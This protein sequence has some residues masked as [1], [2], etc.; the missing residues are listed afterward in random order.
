MVVSSLFTLFSVSVHALDDENLIDSNLSNWVDYGENS[1]LYQQADV[2]YI[3]NNTN[4]ITV[5]GSNKIVVLYDITQ[6]LK[7]GESYQFSFSLPNTEGLNN[8]ALNSCELS[9][10]LCDGSNTDFPIAGQEVFRIS[11]DNA[12][13]NNYL[14]KTTTFEFTYTQGFKNTCL[15]LSIYPGEGFNSY[16]YLQLYISN[17]SLTRIQSEEEGLLNSIIEWLKQIKDNIINGFDNL[18][19]NLI[20]VKNSIVE[21]PQK[22]GNALKSLFVPSDDYFN[23][24][25]NE[26]QGEL[27]QNLGA[28]YQVSNILDDFFTNFNADEIKDFIEVPVLTVDLLGY[29]FTIGGWNIP[30]VP[31]TRL[32]FLADSCRFIIGVLTTFAFLQ[33]LR[34]K[35]EEI[36]GGGDSDN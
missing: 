13:K 26:M 22:I 8:N 7:I 24:K 28:V 10:Y 6:F 2:S 14:G 34:K 1:S 20:D 21:L 29:P 33:G 19:Q 15:C 4:Y 32:Q 12:N 5:S 18:K 35:Y 11:I 23:N 25:I 36:V 16:N 30:L 17:V 9:W 31:D 3:G 27:E